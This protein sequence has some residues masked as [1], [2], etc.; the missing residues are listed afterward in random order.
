MFDL[1]HFLSPFQTNLNNSG[2]GSEKLCVNEPASCNPGLGTCTFFSAKQ[3]SGQNFEFAMAGNTSGYIATV[4][5]S[6]GTLV[7]LP[8]SLTDEDNAQ[9]HMDLVVECGIICINFFCVLFYILQGGNDTAY[10]C[11]QDNGVV[12]F[13][14]GN[15]NNDQL[16]KQNVGDVLLSF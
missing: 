16:T 5:S 3:T 14:G 10:V 13:T 4:L 8:S 7:R 12:K 2:C 15:L 1:L 11:F 9:W 6:D